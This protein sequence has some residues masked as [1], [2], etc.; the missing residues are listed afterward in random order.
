MGSF[1]DTTVTTYNASVTFFNSKLNLLFIK[2][3][4]I[5]TEE[6]KEAG[7]KN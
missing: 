6:G 2:L 7:V 3:K 5:N 4:I 1:I